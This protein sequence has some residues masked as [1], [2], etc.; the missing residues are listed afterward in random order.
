MWLGERNFSTSRWESGLFET[1]KINCSQWLT[2]FSLVFR[3][4]LCF[5]DTQLSAALM[6]KMLSKISDRDQVCLYYVHAYRIQMFL[7]HLCIFPF[8]SALIFPFRQ[9]FHHH[10]AYDVIILS[11]TW[12]ILKQ[13]EWPNLISYAQ[14]FLS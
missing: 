2:F 10:I 5:V 13:T 7:L 9:L 3:K 8:T 11:W 4:I 12:V 14:S 1:P 6:P